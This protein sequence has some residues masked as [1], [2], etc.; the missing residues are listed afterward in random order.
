MPKLYMLNRD[1][2]RFQHMLDSAQAAVSH[3]AHKSRT[4][5]DQDRLL[6]NGIVREL[7]IL[8]EAASQVTEENP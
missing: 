7:E 4:D 6:L 3:I 1:F 8:G 2:T 5:L